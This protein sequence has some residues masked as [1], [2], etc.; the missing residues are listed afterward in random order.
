MSFRTGSDENK[1][2]LIVGLGNPGPVYAGNRHNV[3]YQSLDHLGCI[4]GLRFRSSSGSCKGQALV[5]SGRVDQAQIVLA[6]PLLFMNESGQAVSA[7]VR[8]HKITRSDL[9]IVCDDLDLPLGRIRL[10]AR[11]RSGGHKGLQSVIDTIRTEEFARLRVGIGRPTC[12]E[13]TDYVLSDFSSEERVIMEA[14]YDRIAAA[15]QC[16]VTQGI[17]AAMNQFNSPP[18]GMESR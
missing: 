1:N 9:L 8:W 10:R 3:G 16:F 6:K 18:E 15:I 4:H 2:A 17:E 12:E 14:V 5:A 13:P 11:G 7:L